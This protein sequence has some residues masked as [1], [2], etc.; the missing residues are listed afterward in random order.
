MYMYM[1]WSMGYLKFPPLYYPL[2]YKIMYTY[3]SICMHVMCSY[4]FIILQRKR[5]TILICG[6]KIGV[7]SLFC[8]LFFRLVC[9][10]SDKIHHLIQY[11]YKIGLK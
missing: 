6:F 8:R 10:N 3:Q 2:L 1:V 11:C 4:A 9:E 7:N 5:L